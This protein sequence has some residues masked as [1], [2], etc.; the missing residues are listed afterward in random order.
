MNQTAEFTVTGENP[1]HCE[2]CER[3]IATALK[4]LRGVTR[5]DASSQTQQVRVVFDPAHVSEEQLRT[6]LEQAGF[7][8]RPAH[9]S[10]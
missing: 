3:R 6:R 10:A 4:R 2:G 7:V 8:V 5:V 9:G 1:I